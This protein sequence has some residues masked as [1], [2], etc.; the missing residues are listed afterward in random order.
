MRPLSGS[1]RSCTARFFSKIWRWTSFPL[2]VLPAVS[3]KPQPRGGVVYSIYGYPPISGPCP[4]A[5]AGRLHSSTEARRLSAKSLILARHRSCF[6]RVRAGWTH[7]PLAR[8]EPPHEPPGRPD[9]RPRLRVAAHRRPGG[10]AAAAG[11]RP[12]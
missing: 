7:V 9:D 12:G 11:G 5:H 3:Y 1:T 10:G 2:V 6:G 8:G 4:R